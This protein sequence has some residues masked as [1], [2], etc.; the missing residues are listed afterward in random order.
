MYEYMYFLSLGSSIFPICRRCT[1]S[2]R[3]C[4]LAAAAEWSRV[5]SAALV[6]LRLLSRLVHTPTTAVETATIIGAAETMAA[7]VTTEEEVLVDGVAQITAT[8]GGGTTILAEV[9]GKIGAEGEGAD[10]CEEKK[11]QKMELSCN[12]SYRTCPTV[13]HCPWSSLCILIVMKL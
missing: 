11:L 12:N 1:N 5:A 4:S 7:A 2:N 13:T 9:A 6:V 10:E 3:Q 8:V